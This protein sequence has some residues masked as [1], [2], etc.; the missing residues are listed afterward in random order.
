MMTPQLTI[1]IDNEAAMAAFGTQMAAILK[2]DDRIGLIGD[3]GAGKTTL[4]R[5]ILRA[6]ATDP[7]LEVPSPTFTIVQSYDE[8]R[9]PVRHI[10]L[11]RVGEDAELIELGV[12]EPGAAELIEWP[13]ADLPVTLSIAFGEGEDARTITLQGNADLLNRLTRH[14]AMLRFLASAGWEGADLK[15][16][17][18]DAS[19]RSYYRLRQNGSGSI[20]MDAP[21]FTP[22]EGAYPRLARLA[23]GNNTAFLAIAALLRQRELSAP[24]I[25]AAE[26]EDGF[27]LLEDLGDDKIAEDGI[28]VEERYLAAADALAHFHSAPPPATLLQPATLQQPAHYVPPRF[29]AELGVLEV[30]LFPTWYLR[31]AV[32]ET[33]TRLWHDVLS[34]LWRGDDHLALRDFHSPNCL[35]LP[36]RQGPARVGI[37]DFQDAMVAPSSYDVVSL[38]QDARVPVPAGLEDAVIARYL[39]ARPTLDVARWREGYAIMGA[40]RATRIAGVFRRLNDRDGK[41]QY[42][43]HVPRVVATLAKNLNATPMLEP[44]KDWFAQNTDVMVRP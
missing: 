37:I 10:D 12:G 43:Q 44:L 3:L 24:A 13:R 32:D 6:L 19:T 38:A 8:G 31:G 25:L 2:V 5:A 34:T 9:I 33:Y 27:I 26:P 39:A 36:Q 41:P 18:Q 14:Q 7:T 29:D 22:P 16:L 40:Q 11:Y 17:H 35:W 1:P 15:P 20:V 23:D 21:A 28:A 30:G 42:L 4:A